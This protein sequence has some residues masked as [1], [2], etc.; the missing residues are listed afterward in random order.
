MEKTCPYCQKPFEVKRK[1]ATYCSRT[2]RQMAYMNRRISGLIAN[3]KKES[4]GNIENSN[5]EQETSIDVLSK[6]SSVPNVLEEELKPSIDTLEGNGNTLNQPEEKYQGVPSSFIME[7]S[8]LMDNREAGLELNSC[9]NRYHDYPSAWVSLRFKC[10]LECLLLFSDMRTVKVSSLMEVCNAFI[11]IV[12]SKHFEHLSD[13][14]PYTDE[15]VRLKE[16]LKRLCLKVQQS[17]S[18]KFHLSKE[19]K[20]ELI[21]MRYELAQYVPKRKFSHLN[22]SE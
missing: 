5:E 3:S 22:F 16:K 19:D 9:L 2:C 11:L 14:Y 8:D 6:Q 17:E 4:V 10:L 12:K 15:I 21:A 20:I 7:V 1:D 13:N 18:I